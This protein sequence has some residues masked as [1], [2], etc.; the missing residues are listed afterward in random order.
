M[1]HEAGN[2]TIAYLNCPMDY[3]CPRVWDDL[4]P[5]SDE[6]IRH[7]GACDKD[8]TLCTE[9]DEVLELAKQGACIAFYVMRD[10]IR[11]RMVIGFPHMP[12]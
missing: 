4:T 6:K 9:A 11:P 2:P 8:V 3:E 1:S 10:P 12:Y 5:T 7:C